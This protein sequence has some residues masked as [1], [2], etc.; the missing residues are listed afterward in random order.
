MKKEQ[1]KNRAVKVKNKG[2]N[3]LVSLIFSRIML[4]VVI[5]I[6]QI[7]L[8]VWIFNLLGTYTKW[9]LYALN[10]LA[11]VFVVIIINSDENPAFKLTW[12]LPLCVVPVFGAVLY[13]FI[14]VNPVRVGAKQ[15]LHKRIAETSEYLKQNEDVIQRM[16]EENIPI[17]DLAYYIQ[18]V[19]GFPAY[20][21]TQITYFENGE[22]K[23][24]D[25]IPELQ[26]AE[27]FIFLEYF[28]I[29]PGRVWDEVLAVLEQ[30]AAEGVE[31]RLMYDGFNSILKL[32]RKYPETLKKKGIK[33]RV[34]APVVPFLSSHQNYRDHR[35]ILVIDGKVA[36]NGGINLA[37]EYM[38][39]IERFGYWK[40]T[41][42]K[43]TGDA[44]KS[45]TAMFLQMWNMMGDDVEDYD[46]YLCIDSSPKLSG[47]NGIVIPYNDDPCNGEDVAEEVYLDILSKA[48]DYVYIM[49]P[50]LVPENEIIT[51]L[52]FAAQRGVD[53]RI[54]MPHIPDKKIAFSIAH[55]YYLQLIDA[56]VKIYEFTPGFVHAKMFLADD[57]KAVVGTINLDFRS[58]Y[59]HY[60]CATFIYGNSVIMDIKEDFRKT[61]EQCQRFK[62][63]DY[64]KLP[65]L[66]RMCGRVFRLFAP[67]M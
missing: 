16:W 2:L 22:Q 30:K 11:A 14:Q 24:R 18:N 42:V 4:T 5:L 57:V 51:G 53:V 20:D 55:T 35:K 39:Y 31:I 41:A 33:V 10:I 7:V 34:F 61:F 64:K 9:V 46:R 29:N 40:D 15:R 26:K 1:I 23:L 3:A 44:V 65:V 63:E 13:L 52:R 54:I 49:T 56:G 8:L 25:L 60:E 6:L 21:K 27:K 28:I 38:N 36:Y 19:N 62:R 43:L 67:L 17:A 59:E 12:M 32:P 47:Q 48:K 66:H 37:D 45:F 58:L 50:Y